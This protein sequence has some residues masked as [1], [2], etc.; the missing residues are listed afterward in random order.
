MKQTTLNEVRA[1]T[2]VFDNV[3]SLA[4]PFSW[5]V[6]DSVKLQTH[7]SEMGKGRAEGDY[8]L[9]KIKYYIA[10]PDSDCADSSEVMCYDELPVE[11]FNHQLMECDEDNSES[12]LM[13]IKKWGMPFSPMRTDVTCTFGFDALQG[14]SSDGIIETDYLYSI[15]ELQGSF[16][17][18]ENEAKATIGVLKKVVELL[19]S[20]V[21]E[22]H[23]AFN[24][25]ASFEERKHLIYTR[26]RIGAVLNAGACNPLRIGPLLY[27]PRGMGEDI[28]PLSYLGL[29]TSAI[30]NQIIGAIA[31]EEVPWRKCACIGC[32]TLFKYQQSSAVIPYADSYYCCTSHADKQRKR[33]NRKSRLKH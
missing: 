18:S 28:I 16:I 10:T 29:L 27:D 14:K 8:P 31:N 32:N 26:H 13:F 6:L 22:S 25:L 23:N 9:S 15:E 19:R 33:N 3:P 24:E 21:I 7:K 2:E 1:H 20:Y 12:V 17:I 11:F 30:C 4:H 5:A